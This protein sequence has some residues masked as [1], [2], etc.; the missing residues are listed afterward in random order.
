MKLNE[1]A[2]QSSQFH[3]RAYLSYTSAYNNMRITTW[4]RSAVTERTS[5]KYY[6]HLWR[7]RPNSQPDD[8]ATVHIQLYDVYNSAA[9]SSVS[10]SLQT[11][12]TPTSTSNFRFR[13]F[14]GRIQLLSTM[15]FYRKNHQITE[16]LLTH[17]FEVSACSQVATALA[18]SARACRPYKNHW[19][20]KKV[21]AW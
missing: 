1:T 4:H 8:I 19:R 12:Y 21:H 9:K 10:S 5:T 6:H 2:L 14:S 20:W 17:Y 3:L 15:V 11:M 7:F 13:A 16:T 18:T